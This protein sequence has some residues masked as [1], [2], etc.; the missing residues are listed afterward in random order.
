M[1]TIVGSQFIT[2]FL[3][4]AYFS[5]AVRKASRLSSTLDS[6]VTFPTMKSRQEQKMESSDTESE[7]MFPIGCIRFQHLQD[8]ELCFRAWFA[9]KEHNLLICTG[10]S[11]IM[12]ASCLTPEFGVHS[13]TNFFLNG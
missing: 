5:N 2:S 4:S 6:D 13:L 9:S 3:V 11:E 10:A 12:K 1:P 8:K 7:I